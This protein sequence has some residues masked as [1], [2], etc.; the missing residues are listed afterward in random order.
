L[1]ISGGRCFKRRSSIGFH[2]H[3]EPPETLD[4]DIWLGPAPKQPFHRNLVHYNWHW[5]WDTGN[6]DIGNQGV[7]EMDI[8]RWMIPGATLPKSVISFGGRFGYQDQGETPNTQVAIFDYG[9]TML[10][11]EVRGLPTQGG[12]GNS[13]VFDEKSPAMPRE[14]TRFPG[15]K[16][17]IG[18][19]GPGDIWHNFIHCVRSRREEDLDAHILEAHYSSALCHLANISYRLGREVPFSQQSKAFGDDKLAY[20][21]F[22]A[23]QEHLKQNEVP[24]DGATYRLGRRLLIDAEKEQIIGDAEANRMLRREYRPPFVVPDVV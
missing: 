5:F 4:F 3:Q 24:L 11:F 12:V 8:A 13:Q 10:V 14:V 17:P 18:E 22:A 20:E 15:V 1:L 21:Y 19:R 9:E 16:S 23:M 2:P 6:G 7:H